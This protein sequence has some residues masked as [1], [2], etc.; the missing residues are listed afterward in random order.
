MK[1][2]VHLFLTDI[3]PLRKK[4]LGKF[5]KN[6]LFNKLKTDEVL[7]Q[8]K[9]SKIDGIELLVPSFTTSRDIQDIKELVEK[10]NIRVLSV[11]QAFRFLTIT[12]LPEIRRTLDYA[13]AL[14]A[15]VIVLHMNSAGNQ[16]FEPKYI[17]AIHSLETE[18][19]IKIGFEN[20]E[21]H[22]GAAFNSYGWDEKKFGDLMNKADLHITFDVCH[23]GQAGGNI[24]SFFKNNKERIVNIHLSDY[25]KH[26]LNSSLRPIRYKHLPLGKG[27][28]PLREFLAVLKNE[29]YDG[30]LT[31]ETNTN[32]EDLI[33]SAKTIQNST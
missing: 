33:E 15:E 21:K 28:L 24:I 3:L 27:D 25:K 20:R 30:L 16:L 2:S 13:K 19:G 1:T 9:K 17:A 23:M 5:V 4:I 18:Y 31:L 10:N 14:S 6:K 7:S 32:I 8:I 11:H 22:L 29:K 12:R 26:I